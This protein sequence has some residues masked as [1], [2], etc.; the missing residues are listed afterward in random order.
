MIDAKE[1]GS[2]ESDCSFMDHDVVF[3]DIRTDKA[4][5]TIATHN[6]HNGYYGGFE[7]SLRYFPNKV[8]KEA[9]DAK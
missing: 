2:Q 7:L 8:L 4:F 1:T 6:E 3:V 5:V 9:I